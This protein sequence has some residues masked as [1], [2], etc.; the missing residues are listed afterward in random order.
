[1]R[2]VV[3]PKNV[4]FL[5]TGNSARS[6]LAEAYLNA[7]GRGRFVAH[8]ADVRRAGIVMKGVCGA[9]LLLATFFVA[10]VLWKTLRS[11]A[12]RPA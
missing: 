12:S 10:L 7:K 5:C 9:T 3:Q 6:V 8:S 2:A 11:A 1:M 4:L